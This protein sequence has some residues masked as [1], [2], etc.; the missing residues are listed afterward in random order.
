MRYLLPLIPAADPETG[1]QCNDHVY[2]KSY[3][4]AELTGI[5]L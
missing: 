1:Q 4:S 2:Q 5:T 3:A